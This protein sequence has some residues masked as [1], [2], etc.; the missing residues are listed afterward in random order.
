MVGGGG[1][2][3]SWIPNFLQSLKLYVQAQTI[4]DTY[5]QFILCCNGDKLC[6]L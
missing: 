6:W 2:R 5:H 3:I 4:N 1:G